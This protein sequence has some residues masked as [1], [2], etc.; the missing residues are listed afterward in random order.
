MLNFIKEHLGWCM[1]GTGVVVLGTGAA[2]G[3]N[4]V[5]PL[6]VFVGIAMVIAGGIIGLNRVNGSW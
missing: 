5:V 2:I 4:T 3:S 1:Y 6:L